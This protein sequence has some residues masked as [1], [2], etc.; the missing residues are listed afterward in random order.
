MKMVLVPGIA[1]PITQI[2]LGCGR[3]NGRLERRS[4]ARIVEAALALGIRHFDT[5]PSYGMGTADE[6]LGSV[7]SGVDGVT[8]T[9]KVGI[10]RPQYS[11]KGGGGSDG[12]QANS[13]P[14]AGAQA[15]YPGRFSAESGGARSAPLVPFL[16]RSC[17][18]RT[19]RVA[20][21]TPTR[22][23]GCTAS[24]CPQR[25]TADRRPC[26]RLQ[27]ARDR[28]GNRR[29]RRRRR[30]EVR[31]ACGIRVDMAVSLGFGSHDRLSPTVVLLLSW[32]PEIR[33]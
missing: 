5:A 24:A 13:G 26:V 6:V 18:A 29:I 16:R 23:P 2:A 21:S 9:S 10:A 27:F 33:H 4:S 19:R 7:L 11:W 30:R 15:T 22:S 1:R 31:S 32:R 17:A 20:S 12:G 8:I 3:L 28:G 14:N 25:R